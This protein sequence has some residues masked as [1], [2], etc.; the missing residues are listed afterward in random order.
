[1]DWVNLTD[2]IS[3][4]LWGKSL[5]A[6]CLIT[7][8]FFSAA[9]KFPQLRYLK[10]MVQYLIKGEASKRG[11]SSFQ[12]F[13]M[14]L[15]GKVG[16][17]N[18]AGVATAIYFGGPGAVFWM[19]M[20]AFLGAGS[21]IAESTLAQAFSV[22][23]DTL[24][25]CTATALMIL[26]TG[27][28]NVVDGSGKMIVSNVPDIAAGTGYTQFAIDGI[29]PGFG[30]GFVAIAM[31]FFAFT[32][33]LS[34]AFYADSNIAYIFKGKK[35]HKVMSWAIKGLLVVMIVIGSTR[36]SALA[37]NLADIGVGLMAWVNLVAILLLHKKV[38]V[39]YKDFE[40]Q[41][42]LG[43]NP[44]FNPKDCDLGPLPLWQ[45]KYEKERKISSS[46]KRNEKFQPY[47]GLAKNAKL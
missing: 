36:S 2:Q 27:A 33:L 30:A 17:G 39:V 46:K 7:G 21:A 10:Q 38:L 31:F 42:N 20:I 9:M 34:F 22:Y 24:F 18:I 25:L 44:V 40:R 15:G 41:V 37:W 16:T 23:I 6:I 11:M 28:Y 47:T 3:G 13:A 35:S 5:I 26:S 14:A 1:M 45:E 29:F 4:M 8:I 43:L 19:W 32:T 12:S